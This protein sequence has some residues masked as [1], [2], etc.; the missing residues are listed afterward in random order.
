MLP[1]ANTNIATSVEE[2]EH[3]EGRKHQ[4]LEGRKG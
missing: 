2:R 3:G 4:P 1:F